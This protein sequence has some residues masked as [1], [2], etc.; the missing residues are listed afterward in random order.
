M[1]SMLTTYDKAPLRSLC[2][3]SLS[4]L[5]SWLLSPLSLP[6]TGLLVTDVPS[7]YSWRPLLSVAEVPDL[8]TASTS[9]R[10]SHPAFA[11]KFKNRH[12]DGDQ[13][14]TRHLGKFHDAGCSLLTA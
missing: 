7:M 9:A 2:F 14:A 4:L 1:T 3:T 13:Q 10:L 12:A 6:C 5:S 8:Q 11:V